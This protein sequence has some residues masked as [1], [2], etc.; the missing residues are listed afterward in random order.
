MKFENL[1][2]EE[3]VFKARNHTLLVPVGSIEQHGPHLPLNVDIMI[4]SAFTREINNKLKNT[5]IAPELTF[6]ARSFPNSGGENLPGTVFIS[7]NILIKVY[8]DIIKSYINAGFRKIVFINAHWENEAFLA[9]AI[10]ICKRENILK[11]IKLLMLS[12]WSLISDNEMIEIFGKE[13]IGWHAEHAGKAETSLMM[14]FYPE[15]VRNDKL[16]ICKNVPSLGIYLHPIPLKWIGK[17]GVLSSSVNSSKEYG[18]IL[19]EITID[20]ITNLIKKEIIDD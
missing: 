5:I 10:E 3:I 1:T 20:R 15:M 8:I 4:S 14:Y 2:W 9:E 17:Q 13:F 6:G 19:A 16:M 18:K 11:D 12:W 7:G